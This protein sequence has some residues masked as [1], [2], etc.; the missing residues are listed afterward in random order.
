MFKITDKEYIEKKEKF[1]KNNLP[2]IYN[3]I[4]K[5]SDRFHHSDVA[6]AMFLFKTKTDIILFIKE[7]IQFTKF[8]IENLGR[9]FNESDYRYNWSPFQITA[10]NIL[11]YFMKETPIIW[12][13][14]LLELSNGEMIPR[15][16]RYTLAKGIYD[17]DNNRSSIFDIDNVKVTRGVFSTSLLIKELAIFQI[18]NDKYSEVIQDKQLTDLIRKCLI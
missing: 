13:E 3:I 4:N 7:Y 6:K 16:Y 17:K 15:S 10:N 18:N 8:K 12:F 2:M 14:I 11:L 9:F 1:I 5:E